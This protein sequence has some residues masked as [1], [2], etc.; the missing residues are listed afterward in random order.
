MWSHKMMNKNYFDD[1]RDRQPR[2]GLRI[3]LRIVVNLWQWAAFL[4][5]VQAQI[6]IS[7]LLLHR[8]FRVHKVLK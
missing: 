8:M 4:L 2:C 3:A 5:N 6:Q 7:I 1:L